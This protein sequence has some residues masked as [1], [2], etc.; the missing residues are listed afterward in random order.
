MLLVVA[1]LGYSCLV[2]LT[3]RRFDGRARWQLL[4][5]IAALILIDFARRAL[6]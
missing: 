4:A 6:Q 5:G 1:L 3:A 2:G